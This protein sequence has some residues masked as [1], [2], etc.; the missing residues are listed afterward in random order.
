LF[1]VLDTSKRAFFQR[2]LGCLA[3]ERHFRFVAALPLSAARPSP[4]SQETRGF[5]SPLRNGVAFVVE[6]LIAPTTYSSIY[7]S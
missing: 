3:L 6:R 4:F 1:G 5:A 7:V 2:F